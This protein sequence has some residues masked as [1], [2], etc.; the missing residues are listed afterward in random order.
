MPIGQGNVLL[1]RRPHPSGFPC[2]I[3]A[4]QFFESRVT[5]RR[6]SASLRGCADLCNAITLPSFTVS[7]TLIGE[8]SKRAARRDYDPSWHTLEK[9][10]THAESPVKKDLQGVRRSGTTIVQQARRSLNRRRYTVPLPF[11]GHAQQW[12]YRWALGSCELPPRWR[13]AHIPWY[14]HET[15]RPRPH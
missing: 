3:P 2:A 4:R 11:G 5:S 13:I 7:S 10:L 6:S 12:H 1:S 14:N 15:G 8:S 9:T